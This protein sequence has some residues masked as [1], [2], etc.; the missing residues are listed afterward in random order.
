MLDYIVVGF[1]LSGLSFVEYLD[2]EER[3]FVV[4]EDYSQK[5]SRVAGGLYNPVILKRFTPAWQSL[6]QLNNALPFYKNIEDKLQEPLVFELPILRRFNSVEEQNT[7]FEACDKPILNQFLSAKL[8]KNTN[9][10]LDIP[11]YFGEVKRTGRIAIESMLSSYIQYL[12][13]KKRIQYESFE[14]EKVIVKD[15]Y[16]EYKGIKGRNILFA[17]GFGVKENPFFRYLP[18][19]GNKGEYIIIKSNELKLQEAVKSSIF[20]IPLGDNLYK[21]GA[22]YNN[23]DKSPEITSN[24]QEELQKKLESFLNVKYEIVDQVAGIRPTVR[25]RKPLVGTHP[26]YQNVHILNGLGSRGILIGPSVAKELY[27]HI[28]NDVPLNHEI[29]IKRFEKLR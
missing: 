28:Q 3:S 14:Y 10:A 21:V 20:I 18:L 16:V 23:E 1:G 29:D 8:I 15:D 24:A 12:D 25:D 6:E 2:N 9:T 5:S 13:K 4:F 26:E 19:V 17:E 27:D 7:W 11:Y 22:T